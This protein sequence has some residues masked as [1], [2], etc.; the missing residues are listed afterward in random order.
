[1]EALPSAELVEILS[2]LAS[3]SE[4]DTI[5]DGAASWPA[6]L[7]RIGA[8]VRGSMDEV[9]ELA[10]ELD[11]GYALNAGWRCDVPLRLFGVEACDNYF[12]RTRH[13]TF[14]ASTAL[15]ALAGAMIA[16]EQLRAEHHARCST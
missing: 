6:A 3:A 15:G 7:E 1:M 12:D 4:H 14:T 5:R 8:A 10:G 9:M 2:H 11:I 13:V 16:M